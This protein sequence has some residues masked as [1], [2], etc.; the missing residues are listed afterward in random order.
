MLAPPTPPRVEAGV[1]D[2]ADA[3]GSD[4]GTGVPRRRRPSV[5]GVA[6]VA[7]VTGLLGASGYAL[8]G[9][10]APL[11]RDGD[12]PLVVHG[13]RLGL[14]TADLRARLDVP[15]RGAWR[16][17]GGD[18]LTLT[19]IPD[20]TDPASASAAVPRELRFEFHDGLLV[21]I[22]ARLDPAH[23]LASGPPFVETAGSVVERSRAE[24]SLVALT[25]LASDCPTHAAEAR[26]LRARHLH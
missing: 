8:H 13:A 15:A 23:P 22:R 5:A 11:L 21:A 6:S 17:E 18:A 10:I 3:P 16:V 25:Q 2:Q 7:L 26:A 4:V 14:G 9:A 1:V 19:W 24:E 12:R 20:P